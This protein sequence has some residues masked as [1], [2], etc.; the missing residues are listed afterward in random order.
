ME[1]VKNI[2]DMRYLSGQWKRDGN[3]VALVP[4]M[5][6]LHAGHLALVE[7]A[8]VHAQR[9]VMSIFVNPTQFG[10]GED[11]DRYPRDLAR[12][13]DLA[14]SA[15]VD[16]I[17]APDATAMYP[18]G[19]HT[20]ILVEGVSEG[21]CGASRPGHFRGVATVVAKLFNIVQPDFAVFG[22]K[23]YQQLLVIRQMVR[24]LD[25]PVEILSHPIVREPDGL[26][27]SSRNKYLSKE[28]RLSA[29]SLYRS[30]KEAERLFYS[31][32]RSARRITEAVSAEILSHPGTSIDYIFLGDPEGLEPR[33]PLTD[34]SILAVA[35][36]VGKTRLIDNIILKKDTPA[37]KCSAH[38]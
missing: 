27:M 13:A 7:T 29:L 34:P 18:P 2:R 6:A 8:K 14:L 20:W 12:D 33:D 21:L 25:I 37:E 9:I 31:G 35:A 3:T 24:D 15:G 11:Y 16:C 26:A 17:F 4:T 32:E 10:P 28:E 22:E 38:F 23:D 5:G 1:I 30:L 19:F 36:W